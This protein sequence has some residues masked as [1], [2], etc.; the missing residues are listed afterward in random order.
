VYD[1]VHGIAMEMTLQLQTCDRDSVAADPREGVLPEPVIQPSK[2][3]NVELARGA[4]VLVVGDFARMTGITD[5][6]LRDLTPRARLLRTVLK[7]EALHLL[8][9]MPIDLILA[10]T[11]P[12]LAT[13]E[14]T[15]AMSSLPLPIPMLVIEHSSGLARDRGP[16]EG[17]ERLHV[18]VNVPEL[19][20]RIAALLARRAQIVRI[21]GVS[22][23]GFVQLVEMERRTCTLFV[24]AER[25]GTL[26]FS[27]GRLVDAQCGEHDG[28]PAALEILGWPVTT[29]AYQGVLTARPATIGRSLT[30]LLLE[31]ARLGDEGARTDTRTDADVS[32][33]EFDFR[34]EV[35]EPPANAPTPPPATPVE[36]DDYYEL[37]DRAREQLRAADIDGAEALLL[38]ALRVRPGD[39]VVQQ[40]LRALA[41]RRA[42]SDDR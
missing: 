26:G 1:G 4:S 38:R 35:P 2:A 40:N 16:R 32:F 5:A 10:V 30:E 25:R 11:G 39:R 14:L 28:E 19:R 23:T 24:A 13:A 22:L 27:G 42:R 9:T 21:E 36:T 18:P 12:S 41:R 29:F 15:H 33:N 8:S 17:V 34:D 7:S 20:E 37:L 3:V 31:A 6:A